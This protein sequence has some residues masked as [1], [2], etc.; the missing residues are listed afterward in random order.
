MEITEEY[1]FDFKER[2]IYFNILKKQ[3]KSKDISFIVG[4]R[5]V[6][7]TTIFKMLIKYLLSIYSPKNILYITLNS[8]NLSDCSI[9]D[10][11]ETY[12]KN[13]KHKRK[14][15]KILNPYF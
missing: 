7:K 12:R 2:E 8:Y 14:G 11:I 13:Y 3:L 9:H 1:S 5:R 10:I 15:F 4:L 6:G